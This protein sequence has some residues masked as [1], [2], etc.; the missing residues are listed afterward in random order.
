VAAEERERTLRRE[1]RDMQ[2]GSREL[3]E[4]L[5]RTET[6]SS[7]T[8][9]SVR[10]LVED[11]ERKLSWRERV[12]RESEH[13]EEELRGKWKNEARKAMKTQTILSE[14]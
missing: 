3:K 8:D 11:Y 7:T 10:N 12:I 6:I 9:V 13:R 14:A 4:A 2:E 1:V 5:R